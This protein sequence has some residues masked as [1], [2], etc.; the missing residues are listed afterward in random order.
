M[1]L[2]PSHREPE[3]ALTNR[4]EILC[5]LPWISSHREK[6]IPH[7]FV[8]PTPGMP[9]DWTPGEQSDLWKPEPGI[10]EV[11]IDVPL[12]TAAPQSALKHH[13]TMWPFPSQTEMLKAVIC[14]L[15]F[16]S[17]T[18]NP[19]PQ[20]IWGNYCNYHAGYCTSKY[21]DLSSGYCHN[22]WR[23]NHQLMERNT[24]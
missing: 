20:S 19:S 16:H 18:T 6:L 8:C 1:G 7:P 2:K 17:E 10:R 24:L 12:L 15:I 22:I 21:A 4:Q 23:K 13:L 3:G 14:K 9:K 5:S 11:W